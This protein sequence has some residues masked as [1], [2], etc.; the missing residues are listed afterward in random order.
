MALRLGHRQSVDFDFFS[1]DSFN[2]GDLYKRI[3]YLKGA[4]KSQVSKNTLTCLVK[5][6]NETAKVSFFGSLSFARLSSPDVISN[7]NISIA[8]LAD[9]SATKIHVIQDRAEIKDY[10]DIA[11]LLKQLSLELMLANAIAVFGKEFNPLLSLKA[12]VYYQD[13]NLPQ[14]DERIKQVLLKATNEVNLSK[15]PTVHIQANR[16]I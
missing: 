5:K 11:E 14:L 2:P 10:M 12:L 16:L 4:E 13:G 9:L 15:L 6:Q 1:S 8:S 7:P 3:P